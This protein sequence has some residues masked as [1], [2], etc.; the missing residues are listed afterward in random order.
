M[1]DEGHCQAIYHGA[2][3]LNAIR[4]P[5]QEREKERKKETFPEGSSS[6][7]V[8][9]RER[10]RVTIGQRRSI[11][12]TSTSEIQNG[13]GKWKKWEQNNWAAVAQLGGACEKCAGFG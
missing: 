8:V 13:Y 10:Q 3:V 7:S 12:W 5:L 2:I 6:V 11:R 4:T 1:M 9:C